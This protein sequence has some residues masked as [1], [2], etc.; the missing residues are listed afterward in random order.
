MI[1]RDVFMRREISV[2]KAEK[3]GFI[4]ENDVY[5]Y[6]RKI[7]EGMIAR[8]KI[9]RSGEI[10]GGVYDEEFGEEY[11][12]Y[13]MEDATG[14]FVVG[15]RTAYESL[16]REIAEAISTPKTYVG[17]QANRIHRFIVEKYGVSA[18]FLWERYPHYGVY[19]NS[20]SGKWFAIIMNIGKGKILPGE[21]GM[22]EVMNMKLD[23]YAE[24]YISRGAY[25]S[26]HMNHKSWVT[27]IFDDGVP[28]DTIKEMLE[29][30]YRNSDK[31]N[32]KK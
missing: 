12:N 30:S 16:L 7:Y 32:R 5:L 26:Y 2:E 3:F 8:V 11:V 6:E 1:E 20:E 17:E 28:D 31:K 29:I 9:D 25:P 24:E 27:V 19:R 21:S 23:D 10:R 22:V 4:R 18:E 14:A 13:R 15:V